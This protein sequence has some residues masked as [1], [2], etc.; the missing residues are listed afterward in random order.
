MEAKFFKKSSFEINFSCSEVTQP[1]FLCEQPELRLALAGRGLEQLHHHERIR[2]GVESWVPLQPRATHLFHFNSPHW[3]TN[4]DDKQ[5]VFG[6]C[7]LRKT[8]ERNKLHLGNSIWRAMYYANLTFKF[9]KNSNTLYL[10]IYFILWRAFLNCRIIA[11]C[12]PWWLSGKESAYQ[13]GDAGSIPGLGRSPGEGNG[14]LLQCFCL[15]NP[16]N[17]EAWRATVH[18]VV[19]QLSN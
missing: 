2:E 14:N 9:D 19:K 1:L 17:S 4:V 5:D 3:A 11:L 6:N 13:A 10:H 16:M 12:F 15:R 8:L 18:G 7:L